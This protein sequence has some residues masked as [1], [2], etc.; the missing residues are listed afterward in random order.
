MKFID[1]T[2]V[3]TVD[4]EKVGQIDRV[5][6]DPSS[7]VVT[8]L[9]VE[10]GFLFPEDKVVPVSFVVAANEE[11]VLLKKTKDQLDLQPFVETE[12]IPLHEIDEED[13]YDPKFQ[14]PLYAYPA[15]PAATS[16]VWGTPW[17]FNPNHRTWSV[18][19]TERNIPEDAIALNE[20]AKVYSYD[21]EHVGEIESVYT[22]DEENRVTHF[23]ISRGFFFKDYKLVPAFWVTKTEEEEVRLG[24]HSD[25]LRSLPD[26]A[27][28]ESVP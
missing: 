1:E 13:R 14:R 15:Y 6:I 16:T 22:T 28:Q 7:Q 3:L 4:E 19:V 2:P 9:I 11:Q 5:V 10:K 25:T 12:Y 8:H 24:V 27:F 20:G 26:H 21:G 18:E 23:V 17:F